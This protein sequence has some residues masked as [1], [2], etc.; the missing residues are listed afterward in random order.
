MLDVLTRHRVRF[1]LIGG[2]AAVIHGSNRPTEDI[3]ITPDREVRNLKRLAAALTELGARQK[4]EGRQ[5]AE[6]QL[7][8]QML[9]MQ[10]TWFFTTRY[11]DLDVVIDPAGLAGFSSLLPDA[12]VERIGGLEIQVASLGDVIHSK[13][14]SD[15]PKD[16]AALPELRRLH[17]DLTRG[18]EG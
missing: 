9:R 6:I 8:D 3:D 1:V 17:A 11:G 12:T 4:I 18:A 7:D 13:E 15:R 16:R 2:Y 10:D 5:P 14:A